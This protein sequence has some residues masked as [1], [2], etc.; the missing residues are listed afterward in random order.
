M[1]P[2]EFKK[3][4]WAFLAFGVPKKNNTIRF[5]IDFRRIN[6]NL[7]CHK[8]PLW[9]TEE[10][11]TSIKGF[12]YATSI[13]LNMGYPSIPPNNKARKILTIV[14]PFGAY[15]CLTLPMGVMPA[16]DLFEA[17]MVHIFAEMNERRPFPYID[18]FSTSRET[19][20][21]SIFQFWMRFWV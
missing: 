14:M 8:F 21:R 19:R 6:A 10:I 3:C 17:R 12:L 15:E 16:T 2:E 13:D 20:L 18:A 7:V 11:L 1:T 5:V 9:T 4:E